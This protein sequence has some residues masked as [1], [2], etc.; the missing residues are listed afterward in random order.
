MNVSQFVLQASLREAEQVIAAEAVV[1]VSAEEY[2]WLASLMDE[3]SPTPHLREALKKT[4]VW[5]D[6]A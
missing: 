2:R 5:D 6:R 4:P 3:A 1:T